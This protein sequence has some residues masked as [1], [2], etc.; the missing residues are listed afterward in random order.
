MQTPNTAVSSPPV[1][2]PPRG[3]P[4]KASSRRRGS[5]TAVHAGAAVVVLIAL[6]W[7]A[8]IIVADPVILPSPPD[9]LARGVEAIGTGPANMWSDIR[10]SVIR[11]ATG[12]ALGIAVG[13]PI[14]IAMALSPRVRASLE[15]LI[16]GGRAIPPLAW[17]P[18]LVVWLGI[19][20]LSKVF[21]IFLATIPIVA[22]G[23]TAGVVGVDQSLR[24]AAQTLGASRLFVI[25]RVIVPASLPEV[26]TAARIT[27]GLSWSCLVAA[28]LIAS[29]DGIGYQILQASRYLDTEAIFVGIALIGLLAYAGD[30]VLR[31]IERRTIP[32]K[33]KA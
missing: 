18:L 15:P 2:A 10:A 13:I 30:S 21:L 26:L 25:G 12:W 11:V 24:R 19:G 31:L 6:W 17:T 29:T 3:A 28:E 16:Q 9:V 5:F 23:T 33:G 32:W 4:A 27:Y 1:Q 7:V 22:I 8:S 14:G 20:E